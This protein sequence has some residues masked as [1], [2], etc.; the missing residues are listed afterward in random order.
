MNEKYVVLR[1]IRSIADYQLGKGVGEALFPSNVKV[2]FSRRT[3]KIRH[4][5]LR[6]ELL[7][8][9]RPTDGMFSLT[10]AA[11]KRIMKGV[12]YPKLWV[13]VQKEAAPFIAK[14]TSVFAKHVVD[15]DPEIRPQEEVMVIDESSEVLAVGRAVLTGKEMKAFKRGVAVRVRR[16][17]AEEVKN[18]EESNVMNMWM[19]PT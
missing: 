8:T 2:I 7:V 15:A 10:V 4:V 16:G 6:R 12:E 5:Y 19:E 13:K 11:A 18:A 14:G 9:L 3:G 1:K 17:A